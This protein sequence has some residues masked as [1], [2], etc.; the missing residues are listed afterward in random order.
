MAGELV[1]LVEDDETVAEGVAAVLIIEGFRVHKLT[2]GRPLLSFL[3]NAQP[4]AVILDISLPDIDG[5]ELAED[6][7]RAHPELPIIFTTGHLIAERASGL[8]DGR[9]SYFLQKPFD[10]SELIVMLERIT[11]AP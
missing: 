6:L 10:L 3:A 4:A 11:G 8:S 1:V 9:H 5:V 2:T 7:R